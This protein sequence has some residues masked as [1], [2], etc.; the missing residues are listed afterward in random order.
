MII[1]VLLGILTT[2]LKVIGIT[3]LCILGVILLLLLLLLFVPVRYK[4]DGIY[5]EDEKDA[6]AIIHWFFHIIHGSAVYKDKKV[7]IKVRLFGIP[8]FK[9]LLPDDNKSDD[10]LELE[11]DF[12]SDDDMKDNI[13]EDSKKSKKEINIC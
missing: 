4:A 9:M 11:D 8:V 1:G 2:V 5:N 12:E 7:N 10:D 3:L 13:E 6:K